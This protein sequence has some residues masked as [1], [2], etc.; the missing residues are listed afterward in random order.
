MLSTMDSV[1]SEKETATVSGGGQSR[2]ESLDFDACLQDVKTN[3]TT[4][5]RLTLI[6]KEISDAQLTKLADALAWNSNVRVLSLR[7][8]KVGDTGAIAI[9]QM[10]RK[11]RSLGSISLSSNCVTDVGANE[12]L[13]ALD[14]NDVLYRLDLSCNPDISEETLSKIHKHLDGRENESLRGSLSSPDAPIKHDLV[15]HAHELS[16]EQSSADRA[17]ALMQGTAARTIGIRLIHDAHAKLEGPAKKGCRKA[18]SQLSNMNHWLDT[19]NKFQ[20]DPHQQSPFRLRETKESQ[21]S[22]TV[23]IFEPV[24]RNGGDIV[25]CTF[26]T[27]ERIFNFSEGQV[28]VKLCKQ[29][30]EGDVQAIVV[31]KM[32]NTQLQIFADKSVWIDISTGAQ[33]QF[34]NTGEIKHQTLQ[35][36]HANAPPN[37]A[38]TPL[39]CLLNL[40]LVTC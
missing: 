24:D 35:V 36:C 8:N 2:F 7:M 40:L 38:P 1:D 31:D 39:L 37:S 30:G 19:A 22:N 26:A 5:N 15:T 4:L 25:V 29:E 11:N 14:T 34:D 27:G 23:Q 28:K 17:H 12:L 6:R 21:G 9:A 16:P 32:A 20:D 13:Q 18:R 10:L 3:K 33:V